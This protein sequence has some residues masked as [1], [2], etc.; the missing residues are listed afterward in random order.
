[1]LFPTISFAV[2][3]FLVFYC[4]WL[5]N[6]SLMQKTRKWFLVAASYF[7]YGYW[8]YR[9]ILLLLA[10]SL[11]NYG[12]GLWLGA[13]KN[14]RKQMKKVLWLGVAL[15]LGILGLFKY[16]N[17]FSVSLSNLVAFLG[18][19]S[20]Q[21]LLEVILPVGIS[22]FTFQ[23]ISYLVDIHRGK[24]N[25]RKEVVDVLLYISFFPQLVAGP[26]VRASD[27]LGQLDQ[28]SDPRN[29][30]FGRSVQLIFFGLLKKVW[31][32]NSLGTHLVDPV[33]SDPMAHSSLD[34]WT[35]YFGYA[36]QIYCDFSAYSDIAIGIAA[37]LGFKFHANFDHP[38]KSRSLQEFWRRWHIS[39]SSF[40][41][42]YLY[43]P[44]GGS[45]HGR[46]MTYR[47]LLM[48][49]LLGGLWHGASWN[50]ILWGALHGG[51]LA[52]ERLLREIRLV[53]ASISTSSWVIPLKT[54]WTFFFVCFAW[55]PFRAANFADTKEF[56]KLMFTGGSL[57]MNSVTT[58]YLVGLI[59]LV[60]LSQFLGQK[61][62][63]IFSISFSQWP[64]PVQGF[65]I[66]LMF[67]VIGTLS[68]PGAA[69][70]IYF[71]F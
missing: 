62:K 20:H 39:L 71:A 38:Y 64:A 35:A 27:F 49:M 17:F 65:V 3:F 33:F 31:I 63:E 2:F 53:P 43:I 60:L 1:M 48:T 46:F 7:F 14:D 5:L 8:D 59:S 69:P 45:K 23:G 56:L 6:N 44:L 67:L 12:I 47:N 29:I 28:P 55:V 11:F 32:A 13:E 16:F 54:A 18:L 24:I 61:Y 41:R 9:F 68:P 37:L 26:I 10:S 34:I 58:P 51:Y 19:E 52:S 22:F 36:V 30:A 66:A 15:N 42:D 50:F 40:L 57:S 4:N 25:H 70:F 21:V